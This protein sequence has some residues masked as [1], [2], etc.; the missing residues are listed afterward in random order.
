MPK[1]LRGYGMISRPNVVVSTTRWGST[2][3]T[4]GPDKDAFKAP[5]NEEEESGLFPPEKEETMHDEQEKEK[6]VDIDKH[7][8]ITIEKTDETQ[9]Y[10]G[11]GLYVGIAGVVIVGILLMFKH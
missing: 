2:H 4:A 5:A 6:S 1:R 9:E 7:E 11:Y 8:E 10:F 3:G